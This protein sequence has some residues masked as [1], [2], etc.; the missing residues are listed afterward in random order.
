VLALAERRGFDAWVAQGHYDLG[1]FLAATVRKPEARAHWQAA[2]ELAERCQ[3]VG[4]VT[5]ASA[6]LAGAGVAPA[7]VRMAPVA[8]A[9]LSMVREGELYRLEQGAVSARIRASRGAELLARLVDTP[10]QEIHV[11]ALATDEAG[12][13]T[14]SNAGDSVDRPAL[15]QYRARLKELE[16]L[17]AQA[18]SD[19]DLGRSDALGRERALLEREISRALGLGG[20]ARQT[21]STTERARVNV[22]RRLK[23]ALERVAEAS[24]QLGAWLARCV[25]TGT[26]CSFHPRP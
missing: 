13:T 7:S 6:R 15:R 3:M 21:G 12:A 20:R 24:P 1:N 5:R 22:Q 2:A 26:Y 4:L 23:D 8:S 9:R 19:A 25:R 10:N 14:E 16:A 17:S 11:L 18:E